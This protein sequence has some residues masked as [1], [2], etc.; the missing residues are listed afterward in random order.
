MEEVQKLQTAS[1]KQQIEF[2][3][4]INKLEDE[5]ARKDEQISTLNS[6]M[7]KQSNYEEIRKELEYVVCIF[8]IEIISKHKTNFVQRQLILSSS[9]QTNT[10]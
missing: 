9:G 3:S 6:A 1:S 10:V 8:L 5:L 4:R 7:S 2:L